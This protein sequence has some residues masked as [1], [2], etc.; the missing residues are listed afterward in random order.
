MGITNRYLLS[1]YGED[2]ELRLYIEIETLRFNSGSDTRDC[3]VRIITEND[4]ENEITVTDESSGGSFV[5][6]FGDNLMLPRIINAAAGESTIY[7]TELADIDSTL[8]YDGA[9]FQA[10]LFYQIA[11][12]ASVSAEPVAAV[13]RMQLPV[14]LSEP[15]ISLSCGSSITLGNNTD[16]YTDLVSQGYTLVVTVSD[17]SVVLLTKTLTQS[18]LNFKTER[19]WIASHPTDKQFNVT[20]KFE[21]FLGDTEAVYTKTLTLLCK[22][23]ESSAKPT[24]LVGT[25]VITNNPVLQQTGLILRNRS[26]VKVVVNNVSCFYGASLQS[27]T[28]LIDGAE[29]PGDVSPYFSAPGE[30]S[31]S[32]TLTDSRGFTNRYT[33]TFNVVDYGPPQFSADVK[34][35]NAAG[36]VSMVGS[37]FSVSAAPEVLYTLGGR[38]TYTYEYCWRVSGGNFSSWTAFDPQS[39]TVV[40]A[41]FDS[42]SAY[43]VAVRCSDSAGSATVKTYPLES[44][45]VELHI[46]KNRV[47]VGKK[48]VTDKVFDCQWDIKCGGDVLFTD[49]SGEER[50]LRAFY[51]NTPSSGG[52]ESSGGMLPLKYK[53]IPA[54]SNDEITDFVNNIYTL[55]EDCGFSLLVL[56]V[57]GNSLSL[58]SGLHF[59]FVQHDG[60]RMMYRKL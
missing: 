30:H 59:Y 5:S 54:A 16:V 31:W 55:V 26:N 42:K 2:D 38:L 19:I 47:A 11:S 9:D 39:G 45:R 56:S 43:E 7:E 58:P 4:T 15:D 13:G 27:K 57:K 49:S 6:V 20:V 50:S 46:S 53:L 35:V 36:E 8:Y 3:A 24:A 34:R 12:E 29:Y 32:V 41:G 33:D 10:Q 18:D 37:R 28:V 48:A 23:S 40:N 60:E 51:E 44:D 14:P 1:S 21:A 22:L 25:S 52:V 17:G